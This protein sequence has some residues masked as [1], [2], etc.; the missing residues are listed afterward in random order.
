MELSHASKMLSGVSLLTLPSVEYGG[1]ALLKMLRSG[2]PGY[3]DNPLRQNLFLPAAGR[4]R[5]TPRL[6]ALDRAARPRIGRHPDAARLLSVGHVAAGEP[7]NWFN[8]PRVRGPAT[9]LAIGLLALG[10]GLIRAAI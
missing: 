7:A 3:L 6:A 4:R 8:S 9:V 2:E 5:R 10:V 1:A